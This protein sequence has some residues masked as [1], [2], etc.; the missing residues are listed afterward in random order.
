MLGILALLGLIIGLLFGL[1][2][3]GRGGNDD[4][5]TVVALNGT[6]GANAK[7]NTTGYT[8]VDDKTILSRDKT[9]ITPNTAPTVTPTVTPSYTAGTVTPTPTYTTGTSV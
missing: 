3:I 2:V 6:T 9:T 1:G 4:G 5:P 8:V 7:A